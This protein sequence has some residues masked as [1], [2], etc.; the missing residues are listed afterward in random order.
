MWLNFNGSFSKLCEKGMNLPGVLIEA[1]IAGKKKQLLIGDTSPTGASKNGDCL[2][3]PSTHIYCYQVLWNRP[4]R[5]T[6]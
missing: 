5:K 1:D 6:I 3:L 4:D 2:L